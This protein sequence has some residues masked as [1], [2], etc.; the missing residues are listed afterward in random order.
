MAAILIDTIKAIEHTILIHRLLSKYHLS[1][2]FSPISIIAFYMLLD[3]CILPKN[4][5]LSIKINLAVLIK[6]IC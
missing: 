6:F 2:V 5:C 3:G 1:I 4:F